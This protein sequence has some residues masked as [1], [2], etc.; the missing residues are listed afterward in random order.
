MSLLDE[1][2]LISVRELV[3]GMGPGISFHSSLTKICSF[4]YSFA[5][6][7]EFTVVKHY[8]K[9]INCKTVQFL[10]HNPAGEIN[11]QR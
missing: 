1:K 5:Y 3:A 11:T 4:I 7:I 8:T 2:P 9:N 10:S 6:S